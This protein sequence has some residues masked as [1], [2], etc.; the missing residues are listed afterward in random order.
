MY[1]VSI[2]AFCKISTNGTGR[3]LLRV[4]S[5]HELAV[6]SNGI[7][8]LEHLHQHWARNH[9]FDQVIEKGAFFM[10]CIKALGLLAGQMNHARSH[11]GKTSLFEA[12]DNLT[13]YVFSHSIGLDNR[14]GAFNSH[15]KSYKTI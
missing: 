14:K 11:N 7:F 4:G 9:E 1:C 5:P 8:T 15:V 10:H 2:N 6:F 3:S 13:N 12:C